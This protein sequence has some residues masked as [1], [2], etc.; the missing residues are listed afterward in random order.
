MWG[1]LGTESTY[2]WRTCQSV[3]EGRVCLTQGEWD[4]ICNNKAVPGEK[5]CAEHLPDIPSRTIWFLLGAAAMFGVAHLHL[6]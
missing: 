5:Y 2:G 6:F 3:R 1:H 4:S